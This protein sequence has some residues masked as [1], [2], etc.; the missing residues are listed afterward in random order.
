MAVS[1]QGSLGVPK[2]AHFGW[3]GYPADMTRRRRLPW[4][5]SHILS[6]DLEVKCVGIHSADILRELRIP[7]YFIKHREPIA[8]LTG[9]SVYFCQ[10]PRWIQ[11]RQCRACWIL[12]IR[13]S[14][15]TAGHWDGKLG[16]SR[17]DRFLR[18]RCGEDRAGLR[19]ETPAHC[20]VLPPPLVTSSP[21]RAGETIT[22]LAW[23]EG[24]GGEATEAAEFCW[25]KSAFVM[26]PRSWYSTH[27]QPPSW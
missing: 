20:S 17:S 11:R 15:T 14:W 13:R 9:F 22:R 3:G 1:A 16:C 6:A 24:G 8:S 25:W 18:S 5:R 2:N 7:C 27:A 12:W 4:I 26:S 23:L 19:T 21:P 10:F